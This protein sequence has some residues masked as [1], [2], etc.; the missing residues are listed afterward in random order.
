MY[1][2]ITSC[3]AGHMRASTVLSRL[4]VFLLASAE[5]VQAAPTDAPRASCVSNRDCNYAGRCAH[6][7]LGASACLCD[8]GW[9]GETCQ[10]IV[11]GASRR[12]GQGGLCLAGQQGFTST[13]GGEA[14]RADDGSYHIYAAGFDHNSSLSAWLHQSRVVHGRSAH[15]PLGPY[16]LLDVALGARSLAHWDGLTQHNPAVQRAPDGTYL[17][18]YM[19]STESPG[20]A[21]HPG[22]LSCTKFPSMN[23]SVCRQRV[24]LATASSPDGP[25]TRRDAPIVDV[26]PAGAWDDLFTTNPT[27]HVFPNGS[28]LLLYKARSKEDPS[29]MSTG[30]AFADHWAG[31]Y[32][33]I[34]SHPVPVSGSCEDAGIYYSEVVGVFRMILHCGC[35]YQYLWSLDG[36][37]WERTTP[38]V[39]WCN[40][41]YVDGSREMLARRER[42]KWI[43]DDKGRPVGLLTGV[44]PTVSHGAASFTMAT[45]I[46]PDDSHL[47]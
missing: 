23:I 39:A 21:A 6:G 30:V 13:W 24:G 27:P 36:L 47:R 45:E 4:L 10:R 7:R 32:K 14:V 31:P 15:D 40:V 9:G 25:W 33:R 37:N 22:V 11:F 1:I 41:T 16:E 8:V 19:G 29:K 46:L 43:V 2:A 42:P 20:G 17:L 12:C 18:F 26:G 28:V 34:V 44:F 38:Q 5:H 35:N 3:P